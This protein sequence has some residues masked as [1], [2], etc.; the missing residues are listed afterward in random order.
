MTQWVGAT[1]DVFWSHLQSSASRAATVVKCR[2]WCWKSSLSR[3]AGRPLTPSTKIK[4]EPL[5]HRSCPE[6]LHGR[7]SQC[8]KSLLEAIGEAPSEEELFRFMADVDEDGTGEIEFAEFL[9][10]FEK[11]RGG[12]QDAGPKAMPRLV[13]WGFAQAAQVLAAAWS[14]EPCIQRLAVNHSLARLTKLTKVNRS[15]TLVTPAACEKGE[16]VQQL[17]LLELQEYELLLQLQVKKQKH[18]LEAMNTKQGDVLK[19]KQ[20]VKPLRVADVARP[21]PPTLAVCPDNV[22]TQALDGDVLRASATDPAPAPKRR[23]RKRNKPEHEDAPEDKTE[24]K[25]KAKATVKAKAKAK[26]A[27]KKSAATAKAAPKAKTEKVKETKS[28][29]AKAKAKT[30]PKAKSKTRAKKPIATDLTPEQIEH[31]AKCSRK[32]GAYH[33]V[34]RQKLRDGWSEDAAREEGKKVMP[35]APIKKK[36]MPTSLLTTRTNSWPDH[37]PK[38][39]PVPKAL[40]LQKPPEPL[41]PP[42]PAQRS[43]KWL[44]RIK[45]LQAQLACEPNR[46]MPTEV[47]AAA[48]GAPAQEKRQMEANVGP[49]D[50]K[51]TAPRLRPTS[52]GP[53][54]TRLIV[55]K[56]C[57]VPIQ[58][59]ARNIFDP[60]VCKQI[61]WDQP[62][63]GAATQPAALPSGAPELSESKGGSPSNPVKSPAE[64][65]TPTTTPD[66]VS[67]TLADA[68]TVIVVI[69]PCQLHC[70]NMPS[71]FHITVLLPD[72][73]SQQVYV[74]FCGV[75]GD[76]PWQRERPGEWP[77]KTDVVAKMHT[78]PGM[79]PTDAPPDQMHTWHLGT[80]QFVCGATVAPSAEIV[81]LLQ[82]TFQN[83]QK[84]F[85]GISG[86]RT[87]FIDNQRLIQVEWDKDKDGRLDYREFAAIFQPLDGSTGIVA[88]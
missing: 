64:G 61:K 68:R 32:S 56:H 29:A 76:W 45:H 50:A 23:G 17:L 12:A 84:Y 78:V 44:D 4:V 7:V 8:M 37:L 6:L 19:E 39:P 65:S 73:S 16:K 47:A 31:K 22:E 14:N 72:G 83:I 81:Q 74:A 67:K 80:G 30:A 48:P 43:W 82:W 77:S 54:V 13:S 9:R 53:R 57:D 21:R 15:G 71:E 46:A 18:N 27:P 24:T 75:K 70:V 5:I 1:P 51:K 60:Q 87:G 10:A 38:P 52:A 28:K 20:D 59:H 69:A 35:E 63:A 79:G 34:Y 11:Q 26:S 42:K 25:T 33:K 85:S 2:R 49:E 86:K 55:P 41:E 40:R 66:W 58:Q 3:N 62:P 88:A 36:L